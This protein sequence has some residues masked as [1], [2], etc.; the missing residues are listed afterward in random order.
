VKEQFGITIHD[1][2]DADP[3]KDL[4]NFAAQIAA[5]DLVI[6]VDNATVHM[7]G[8]LGVPT[9]VL[10]P[11]ACDWRWMRTY[12]DT[13]WY[14]SVRLIRQGKAGDWDGVFQR[15][16]SDLKS[17]LETGRM[18]EIT[19][20]YKSAIPEKT[21]EQEPAAPVLSFSSDTTYRCAVIT[22][23]GPGHETLYKESLA[24][25][26]QAFALSRGAFSEIIPIRIDDL[27]GKL[28]RSKAR[29]IGI[30]KAAEHRAEWIFFL[31]ADDLMAPQA[32]EYVSPYLEHYDGIWGSIWSI[33]QGETTPK[34]RPKQLPFLYS[35]EDVLSCDPFVT[36]QMGH[37]VRTPIALSTRFD[38]SLDT[39][40]DFDYYLRVW[41]KHRC[42]KTSLPFFYNRRGLHAQGP[43]AATGIAWRKK[44]E[45]MI[46]GR[47]SQF[48]YR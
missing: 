30:Q 31:D 4:D 2:D 28:G 46:R 48:L 6:S 47:R 35:I 32:F 12:E 3:L 1:W 15:A 33:E 17:Y 29:N 24:S 23:F 43:R 27:E 36:L 45:D 16:A 38:E 9:W 25:V 13:P 7:A 41:E 20:S 14:S 8:A 26:K 37:F 42:I 5:L 34:E 11:F 10:L 18:P 22:P 44:V 21:P 19:R 40:E 39:G